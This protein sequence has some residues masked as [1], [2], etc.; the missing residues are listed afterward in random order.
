MEE[1]G[2][3][4][5]PKTGSSARIYGVGFLIEIGGLDE[6]EKKKS[7]SSRGKDVELL[8]KEKP[9]SPSHQKFPSQQSKTQPQQHQH[10]PS[11][12]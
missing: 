9:K 11:P 6:V 8:K 3:I 2:V 7:R 10:P 1:G 12:L 4:E 5:R